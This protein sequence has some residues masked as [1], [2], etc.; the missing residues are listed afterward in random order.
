MQCAVIEFARH[1]CGSAGANSAEFDP[2]AAHRVID[3][4]PEQR[5]VAD[6][7]ARCA[8]PLS[9]VLGEEA[10]RRASTARDIQER[11]RTVYEVNNDYLAS[12]RKHGLARLGHLGEKQLVEI[13]EIPEHRT[14]WPVSSIPNFA[15][16]HGTPTPVRLR[17]GRPGA[18]GRMSATGRP[19]GRSYAGCSV[20]EGQAGG[21]SLAISL[22]A[23]R[24]ASRTDAPRRPGRRRRRDP[25]RAAAGAGA[26][27]GPVP[28][29][30]EK[31]A[32]ATDRTPGDDRR[33]RG[34][35]FIYKSS[36][37]KATGRPS[38]AIAGRASPRPPH[39]EKGA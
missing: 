13:I 6:K 29:E 12:S 3:L 33:E 2:G 16:A 25:D 1:V 37:D 8:S 32:L 20:P 30:N 15:R 39:P 35:P 4:L 21:R 23:T 38:R 36:Y 10:W 19:G 24:R 5:A 26:D 27:R 34:V 9:I 31:H 7:A 11:H 28:I 22:T 17:P 14:S 18:S